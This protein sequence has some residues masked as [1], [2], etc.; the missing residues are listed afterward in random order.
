ME[1]TPVISHFFLFIV[2]NLGIVSTLCIGIAAFYF[3]IIWLHL[4]NRE[5]TQK[6]A[7]KLQIKILRQA[8]V[9]INV[10]L[11]ACCKMHVHMCIDVISSH[12]LKLKENFEINLRHLILNFNINKNYI[13]TFVTATKKGI[14]INT[15]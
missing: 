12:V 2:P 7:T 3:S 10:F 5:I 1:E 4:G 8:L 6:K 14:K 11:T 15:H 9:F 13:I